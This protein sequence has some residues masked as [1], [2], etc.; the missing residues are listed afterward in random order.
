[1]KREIEG[2]GVDPELVHQLCELAKIEEEPAKRIAILERI[3]EM[4]KEPS[5][6]SADVQSIEDCQQFA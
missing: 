5:E 6:N 1:M 4:Q 3:V 2:R